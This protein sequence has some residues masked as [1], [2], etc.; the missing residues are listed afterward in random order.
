MVGKLGGVP[1]EVSHTGRRGSLPVQIE[2]DTIEGQVRLILDTGDHILGFIGGVIAVARGD[3]S[4]SP[5]WRKRLIAGEE[6][7][8]LHRFFHR[9]ATHEIIGDGIGRLGTIC[10]AISRWSHHSVDI[11]IIEKDAIAVGRQVIWYTYIM[12]R[13]LID[14][15]PSSG[16]CIVH[17]P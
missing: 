8:I 1:F 4:Q 16:L 3:I 15:I 13:R 2:D 6:L 9:A 11:V 14:G 12:R 10:R 17:F 7:I 5:E